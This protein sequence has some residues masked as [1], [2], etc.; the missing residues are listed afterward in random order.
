MDPLFEFPY[1]LGALLLL[2]LG[3]GILA[4]LS[5]VRH[6]AGTTGRLLLR[7]SPVEGPNAVA[8]RD[9]AAA[10]AV[11]EHRAEAIERHL[12]E[13]G[14]QQ[15][16]VRREYIEVPPHLEGLEPLAFGDNDD[17]AMSWHAAHLRW[18]LSHPRFLLAERVVDA[19]VS[20]RRLSRSEAIGPLTVSLVPSRE[21][22]LEGFDWLALVETGESAFRESMQFPGNDAWFG[23]RVERERPREVRAL[24]HCTAGSG[25]LDGV[26]GGVLCGG[27]S[28]ALGMTCLHVLSNGCGSQRVPKPDSRSGAW[29]YDAALIHLGA[30]CFTTEHAL[31]HGVRVATESEHREAVTRRLRVVKSPRLDGREGYIENSYVPV[32]T[33]KDGRE[34]RGPMALIFPHY[35]QRFGI[36]FPLGRAPFSRPGQSGAWVTDCDG[37]VWFGM[38]ALGAEPPR[39]HSYALRSDFLADT[40]RIALSWKT[41]TAERME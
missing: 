8:G 16:R 41:L 35:V 31:R 22:G 12:I 10:L 29:P 3:W 33:C 34:V 21:R 5:Q 2:L 28:G 26:V 23:L 36:W 39:E 7:R 37:E 19:L 18:Q 30:E 14:D 40:F 38:V 11:A 15:G 1:W 27:N 6:R 20:Q 17:F 32:A 13:Y 4:A 9:Y 25:G 24:G